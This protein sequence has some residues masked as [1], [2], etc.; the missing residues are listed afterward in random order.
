MEGRDNTRD[1]MGTVWRNGSY[2]ISWWS[3]DEVIIIDNL[4]NECIMLGGDFE[5]VLLALTAAYG[6][7]KHNGKPR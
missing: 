3:E 7:G 2:E 6:C 4:G 5:S 1:H